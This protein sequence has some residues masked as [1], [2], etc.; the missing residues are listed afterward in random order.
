MFK[1]FYMFF[2][3]LFSKPNQ[4]A[5]AEGLL[6]LNLQ[7]FAEGDP[8]PA[9]PLGT[10]DPPPADPPKSFTQEDVNNLIAKETKTTQ[11]KLLKQLGIDDFK[12]AKDGLQKFK[13]WQESQK[14]DAQKQADALKALETE[15]GTLSEENNSLKAQ[16]SAMK[17]GVTAESVEDVVALAQRLVNDDTSI[18]QAISQVVEKYPHFKQQAQQQEQGGTQ[19]PSFSTGQHQQGTQTELDKWLSAFK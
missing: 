6:R 13:E 4:P 5:K 7:H 17:A 15:K 18:D 12:N 14:T 10:G 11:E 1:K 3:L 19:K 16:V 8:P 2:V 9:D